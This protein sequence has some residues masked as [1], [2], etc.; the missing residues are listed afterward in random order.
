MRATPEPARRARARS[1]AAA[2]LA[3][4]CLLSLPRAAGE[5]AGWPQFRG[6]NR[7]G[8]SAETGLLKSW[9]GDGPKELWRTELGRG[10][11]GL[12]VTGGRVY[13]MYARGGDEFLVSLDAS[14]GEV[15]WRL[16]TDGA[17]KDRFGDGPRST[18]TVDDGVVYAMSA[19]GKLY[20]VKAADGIEVWSIDLKE[21]YGADAP[22]WGVATSPLVEGKLLLVDVGGKKGN[23]II[24][25]DKKTGVEVWKSGDD[26]AGYASPIAI[27]VGGR[28]Q[29]IV[30]TAMHV[31]ALS[32]V[33][34]SLYWRVPWQ[35]SYDVNAATPIFVPPNGLFVSSGYDV[36]GAL[37]RIRADGETVDVELVWKSRSMKNQF[38]SSVLHDGHLYGFDEKTLKC[39]DAGTGETLWRQREFGHGSLI[40]ADGHLI[41]LGDRGQLALVEATPDA[42]RQKGG[43]QVFNGKTWTAP[44]LVDGRL[45]LRDERELVVL[46]VAG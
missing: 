17:W 14:G 21:S 19:Q 2:L 46:D 20:A 39:I 33:D 45:Y 13:T 4:A 11:S 3:A 16:R 37:Y 18:P 7:D 44:T 43:S 22:R 10:F 15:V 34:G 12:S 41:V 5:S 9:P 32:P 25:F 30:F 42:Y 8:V 36:G 40:Y 35:T 24:A 29:V 28:R 1:A 38:S 26:R 23:S 27:T 31:V 6:P